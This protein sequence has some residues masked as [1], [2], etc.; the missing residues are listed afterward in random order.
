MPTLRKNTGKPSERDFLQFF[1][2][3]GKRAF[4]HRLVDSA[5]LRGLN[6]SPVRAP[7]QPA[8][9]VVT[10]NG[11]TYYA[12][13]KS[14]TNKT[15]FPFSLITTNEEKSAKMQLAAGGKYMFFIHSLEKQQWFKVPASIV[16]SHNKRSFKWDELIPYRWSLAQ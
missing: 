4:V 11:E 3:L 1:K 15:S 2:K 16:L 6:N 13:V 14:T 8:D 5:D 12:E 10:E 9:W 7:E